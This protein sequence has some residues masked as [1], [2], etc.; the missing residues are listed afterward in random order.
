MKF[1]NGR[2]LADPDVAAR[3]LVELANAHE[4]YMDGR[5][6]IERL[7]GRCFTGRKRRR[8]SKG[9]GSIVRTPTVGWC[10]MRA[11]RS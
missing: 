6:L 4:P 1:V 7:T 5:I 3:K 10:C 9:P 11:G 2:L 8:R